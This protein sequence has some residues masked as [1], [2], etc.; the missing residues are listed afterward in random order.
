MSSIV[1]RFA[2][3]AGLPLA[4]ASALSAQHT[5]DPQ[6]MSLAGIRAFAV[7]A[8]V[9]VV[10]QA[11]LQRMDEALLRDNMERAVRRAGIA[12]QSAGDVRNGSGAQISLV[13]LVMPI[14]DAAGLE[15]GFAASSCLSASQYVR[16]PRQERG[17]RI[18]YTVAPTWSSCSMIV[19]DTASY[20][21]TLLQNAD[22]QIARFLDAWRSVNPAP[23]APPVDRAASPPR[24]GLSKRGW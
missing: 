7:H 18:V 15:A 6:R 11:T 4:F 21:E 12:V 1:T 10:G 14:R 17:G 19:G 22:G 3:G 9:Q 23:A 5:Q 16:L 8:Q 20:R 24:L 2:A 13:Y